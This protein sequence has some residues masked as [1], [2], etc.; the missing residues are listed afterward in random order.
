MGLEWNENGNWLLTGSRDHLVKVFDIRAMKEIAAFRGHKKEATGNYIPPTVIIT[1]QLYVIYQP[2]LSAPEAR[3]WIRF[4]YVRMFFR[5]LVTFGSKRP[6]D[7]IF[8]GP[9]RFKMSRQM[10]LFIYCSCE[11]MSYDARGPFFSNDIFILII[12]IRVN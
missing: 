2:R 10:L 12:D 3:A 9:I 4:L 6:D 5:F 1:Y 7:L 11:I 8:A